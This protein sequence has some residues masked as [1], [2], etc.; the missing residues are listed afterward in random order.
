MTAHTG[1]RRTPIRY[2]TTLTAIGVALGIA[3]AVL[4][5]H[6]PQL[7]PCPTEDSV[8]CYWDGHTMG[9]GTG[10]SYTVD[11]HGTLT[12][13]DCPPATAYDAHGVE[14]PIREHTCTPE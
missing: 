8:S 14:V 2:W 1:S 11:A 4:P 3:Y 7:P 9:N 13:T 6:A 10:R 12:Y 5:G